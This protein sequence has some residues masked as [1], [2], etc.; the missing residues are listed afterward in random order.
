M[1]QVNLIKA[2]VQSL[3]NTKA[4]SKT[5]E[6]A[7]TTFLHKIGFDNYTALKAKYSNAKNGYSDQDFL[8]EVCGVRLNSQ[9]NLR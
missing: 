7:L 4:T 2:L 9:H 6:A 1:S 5:G 3:V 8:E